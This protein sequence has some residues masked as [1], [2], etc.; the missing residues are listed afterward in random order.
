LTA[1][2]LTFAFHLH[3]DLARRT[4]G[5]IHYGKPGHAFA[6]DEG[7]F[8]FGLAAVAGS[9]HRAEAALGE[10]HRLNGAVGVL[11]SHAKSHVHRLQARLQE[12]QVAICQTI[13]NTIALPVLGVR[14][15]GNRG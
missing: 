4:I 2:L 14:H 12:R 13:Q 10:I 11:Q 9:N 1:D 6:T 5:P 7:N 3:E 15:V 8:S